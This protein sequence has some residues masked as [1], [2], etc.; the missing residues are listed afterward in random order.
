MY[1]N[2]TIGH[3]DFSKSGG[4]ATA[5]LL[6]SYPANVVDADEN[7]KDRQPTRAITTLVVFILKFISF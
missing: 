6:E 5:D 4:K 2:E 7:K 1:E 3:L